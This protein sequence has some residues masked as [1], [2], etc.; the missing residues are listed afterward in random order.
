[1]NGG[2]GRGG[3]AAYAAPV[4]A[5]DAPSARRR[6]ALARTT[7]IAALVGAI[8]VVV[9]VALAS[10]PVRTP[11]QDCGA[12]AAFLLDG[13]TNVYAD[14]DE[15]PAGLTPAE[16]RANNDEPC[17]ERAA[18]RARPAAVLVSAGVVAIG[19][20]ALVEA[21]ARWRWRVLLRRSRLRIPPLPGV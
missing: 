3:G 4:D 10:R 16:V 2:T 17:Q 20:A 9:G 6:R 12:A 8:A 7:A 11:L 5:A 13:R 19:V 15:P 1:M 14:P 21:L 18:N